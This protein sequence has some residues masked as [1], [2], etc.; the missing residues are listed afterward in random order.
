MSVVLTI[1]GQT[2]DYP[3]TSDDNWGSEASDWAVAVS[4]QLLQ[5]TGGAFTLT[6]DVN[7]GGSFGTIQQ[8]L[9]SRSSNISPSG[10]IRMAVGDTIVWRNNANNGNIVLAVD[11]SDQVTINGTPVLLTPGGVLAV[12]DG[13]TGLSSYT[14]GDLIYA[15]ATTTLSKLGIGAAST[16][17]V[18]SGSSLP[19]WALLANANIDSAAQIARSKLADGS[20]NHVLINTS[21]GV[22]SSE[23]QL[24][25]TRGGTGIS[26]TA[27]FPSSGVVV[28]EAATQTLTNKTLTTPTI[29]TPVVN[30]I[31]NAVK[32]SQTSTYTATT[33]DYFIPC[34]ATGGA[35]TID[36]PAASGNTGLTFV[37][38]KTDSSFNAVTIDPNSSETIDGAAT[39]TLNTQF[40]AVTIV[41][42]GSNWQILDR[43]IPAGLNSYTPTFTGLGSPSSVSGL[44]TRVGNAI[45]LWVKVTSGTVTADEFRCS[46]PSGLTSSASLPSNT[47]VAGSF[48]SGASGAVCPLVLAEASV[49]YFTA[50]FQAAGS[51]GLGKILGS[52]MGSTTAFAFEAMIPITGWNG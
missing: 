35:L 21:G 17:L 30:G 23:A 46:L 43:K 13:G 42:D 27:T 9:K 36:L 5:R 37:I 11:G 25:K 7:F 28:T 20:A 40:E 49:T 12:S 34:N 16:V 14:A 4:T 18:R 41:C 47:S 3:T 22:M 29:T 38:K 19:S 15:S 24:D 6:N 2:F 45:K 26:S 52:D 51:A 1:A 8:Y 44:W 33:T 32:A 50:G 10:F 39:T 48:A 31:K